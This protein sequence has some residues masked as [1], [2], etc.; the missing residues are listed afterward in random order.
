VRFTPLSR[1]NLV[2]WWP[3]L[4]VVL[5]V[6]AYL[7][8]LAGGYL[9]WD[10]PWLIQEGQLVRSPTWT[11]LQSILF[12]LDLKTRYDLGAEYL[13]VRDLSVWLDYRMHAASPRWMRLE[14]LAL[15]LVA[16]VALRSAL[17]ATVRERWVAEVATIWF[18]LHPVHVES[19]AWLAGRKDVLAM[20]AVALALMVHAK[21]RHA[22]WLVPILVALA[23]LSKSMSVIAL[24]LIATQDLL[25]RRRPE[26][27]V[28]SLTA[29]VTL[30]GFLIHRQVGVTVGMT[31]ATL[32]GGRL[33]AA[34]TMGPVWLRYLASLAWPPLLS[35]VQDV[36]VLHHWELISL[37]GWAVVLGWPILGWSLW[38]RGRPVILVASIWF[39]LGLLPVSQILLTLQNRMADRYLLFSMMGPGL[40]LAAWLGRRGRWRP[41]LAGGLTVGL[42]W[43]TSVRADLFA[44]SESVFADATRKTVLSPIAPFMLGRALEDKDELL[45]AEAAYREVLRRIA[46]ADLSEPGRR[47]TNNLAR[48]LARRGALSEAEE[49]LRNGRL[50]WPWD[51]K[52]LGNLARVLA[53]QGR[54]EEASALLEQLSREHPDYALG[55]GMRPHRK[56]SHRP[57]E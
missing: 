27:W 8:S 15:W 49:V 53:R 17:R 28:Y 40:V 51:P 23:I 26:P 31:A 55:E 18:A 37:A 4:L 32:G 33:D 38:R 47:S 19:V 20:A 36:P 39:L 1:S 2:R 12:K 43:A 3:W 54:E 6:L 41:Y 22:R 50:L 5:V 14:N 57:V 9:N 16:I 7:P 45:R 13:P 44:D 25:R 35:I 46:P 30:A 10:D 42:A 24:G 56:R 29:L 48:L 52:I 34:M 21:S 11:A